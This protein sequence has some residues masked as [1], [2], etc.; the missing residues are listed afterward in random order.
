MKKYFFS[1]IL[2]L[3]LISIS[4]Y[5]K[6][7]YIGFKLGLK[8]KWQV[9]IGACQDGRGVCI[10]IGSITNPDNAELGYDEAIN[11]ILYLKV[12]RSSSLAENFSNGKFVLEEDSP[13]DPNL[14]AKL[15]KFQCPQKNLVF[16]RKGIYPVKT[17]G[18]FYIIELK[19]YLY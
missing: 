9:A 14:I 4:A 17:A 12:S 13:I 5:S 16:I 15:K 10:S 18:D 19:Y 3:M 8:A 6:P 11:S 2:F 1:I 7:W